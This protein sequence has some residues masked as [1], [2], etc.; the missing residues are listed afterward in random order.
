[1]MGVNTVNPIRIVECEEV[2]FTN[3]EIDTSLN[4]VKGYYPTVQSVLVVG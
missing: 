4:D 3:N 1:M 2:M